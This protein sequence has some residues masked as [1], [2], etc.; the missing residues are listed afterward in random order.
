MPLGGL[1]T[2]YMKSPQEVMLPHRPSPHL[3]SIAWFRQV[4]VLF[5]LGNRFA[6]KY[7]ESYFPNTV[8]RDPI[9]IL[10]TTSM[11]CTGE[12]W[13]GNKICKV[14]PKIVLGLMIATDFILFFW[15]PTCGI[16][17]LTLFSLGRQIV[18]FWVFLSGNSM[19]K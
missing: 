14:Q 5:G 17:L 11:R 2:S 13:W 15:I 12:Y 1:F 7:A 4:D 10:S 16:S 19:E 9:R 18:L 8:T 3:C 6:A